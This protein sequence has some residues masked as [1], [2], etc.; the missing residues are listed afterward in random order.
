MASQ[1]RRHWWKDHEPYVWQAIKQYF[2]R[3][4]GTELRCPNLQTRDS[5]RWL[6]YFVRQMK[7][8]CELRQSPYVHVGSAPEMPDFRA[9]GTDEQFTVQRL[10]NEALAL[11]DM[12]VSGEPGKSVAG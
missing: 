10:V 11:D 3:R 4:T 8:I 7:Q 2:E 6:M 12:L 5:E 9:V 1:S